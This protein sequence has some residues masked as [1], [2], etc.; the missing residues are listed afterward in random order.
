[1]AQDVA[2]WCKS[3]E[4]T[5]YRGSTLRPPQGV[6]LAKVDN[7]ARLP[8]TDVQI[9]VQGP[10]TRSEGGEYQ[11]ILSYH[12]AILGIPKLVP[13]QKLQSGYFSRALVHCVMASRTI[14]EIV[15]SDRG[16]EMT[17]KV[18][19][20][21]LALCGTMEKKGAAMT[22][23][24]Q[25]LVE[26]GHHIT[27]TYHLILMNM[28]VKAFPQEWPFLVPVLEYLYDHA[29]QGAHGIT[30][31]DMSTGYAIAT[32]MDRRLAPFKLPKDIAETEVCKELFNNF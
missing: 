13:M 31:H 6:F 26:K 25:G 24:H 10:Y 7:M 3:C 18:K 15:R 28:V 14:P 19:E 11:Y 5:K 4:C 22:P 30:A 16:P 1:M 23:R 21:F 27:A 17:S 2:N 8:W 20:E 12:C 29:P 32:P 9:D